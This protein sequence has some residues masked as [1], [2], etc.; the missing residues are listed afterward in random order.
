MYSLKNKIKILELISVSY[1]YL[2]FYLT[3]FIPATSGETF[4]GSI[5]KVAFKTLFIY[6]IKTFVREE[7][8]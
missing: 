3:A 5:V 6:N 7:F 1:I 4:C 2:S 8:L